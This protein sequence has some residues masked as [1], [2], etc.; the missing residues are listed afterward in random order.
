MNHLIQSWFLLTP[1]VGCYVG[2]VLYK[3]GFKNCRNFGEF[4]DILTVGNLYVD[5][6]TLHRFLPTNLTCF[7]FGAD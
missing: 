4:V 2:S 3:N 1:T 5:I 6:E 7:L